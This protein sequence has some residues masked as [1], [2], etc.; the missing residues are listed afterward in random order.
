[1]QTGL[2]F[3]HQNQKITVCMTADQRTQCQYNLEVK[4]A[5]AMNNNAALLDLLSENPE[6]MKHYVIWSERKRLTHLLPIIAEAFAPV[7]ESVTQSKRSTSVYYATRLLYQLEPYYRK[8]DSLRP[9]YQAL[10]SKVFNWYK[11]GR[12][13]GKPGGAGP[14]KDEI[15]VYAFYERMIQLANPYLEPEGSWASL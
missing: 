1:M 13:I 7:V 4:A 8:F 9:K 14:S 15:A 5:I 11:Q 2:Y 12:A 6:R 3:Q 10:A